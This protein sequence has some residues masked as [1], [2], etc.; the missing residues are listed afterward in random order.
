MSEKTFNNK[1]LDSFN[2]VTPYLPCFFSEDVAF[3]ISDTEKYI[4][5]IGLEKFNLNTKIGDF[6]HNDGGDR[7]ALDTGTVV[8]K[9]IPKEVFGNEIQ[10]ISVPLKDEK[11]NIIGCIAAVKNVERKRAISKLS[12]DLSVA[13][14][15]ITKSTNEVAATI[16]NVADANNKIVISAEKTNTEAQ[17]TDEILEFVK[18]VAKKTNLLG[19]NAAIEAARAGEYGKG[20]NVVATEIRK[21]S[22]SS[23]ESIRKIEDVIKNMQ[24]SVSSITDNIENINSSFQ[25][26]A[27]ELQEIN[28]IIEDLSNSSK[29][30][31]D[32]AKK[33]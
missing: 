19:L 30:L 3:S 23:S 28:A 9:T 17:N 21:L 8:I 33:Y 1:L 2:Q 12:K 4:Q 20:F 16:Q 26:E 6:I 29:M 15:K 22:N 27:A 24:Q 18:N 13:L 7:K 25:S 10:N 31:E 14:S 32:L 11:G 5:L